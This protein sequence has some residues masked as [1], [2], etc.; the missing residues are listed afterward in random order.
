MLS[1]NQLTQ[2]VH[3]Y[4]GLYNSTDCI[5]QICKWTVRESTVGGR[6]IIATEDILCGEVLFVDRPLI[7]GPRCGNVI[8]GCTVCSKFEDD[9][10]FKCSLC[11]LLLCSTECQDFHTDDCNII[12]GWKKKV[13]IEEID[14]IV[15]SHA[16]AAIRALSLNQ[17]Q[18]QFMSALA[19][20]TLPQHGGEIIKLK[21]YFEIPEEIEKDMIFA[22]QA[23]DTNAFQIATPYGKKEMS[24]R[25]LYPVAGLMNHSC[26][27][28]A[29]YSY[30]DERQMI[31]KTSRFIAAGTEIFTCYSGILWGTTTRRS[32]LFKTKHFW[33]KCERC[34][35]PT[36]N[37]TM[38]AALCCL[39]NECTTGYLLPIEPLK[40][41]S[42]W[43]C[44]ACGLRVPSK[45]IYKIQVALGTLISTLD[46][47]NLEQMENFLM[48]RVTK[49]VPKVNHIVVDLQCR[50]IWE[51]GDVQG[52]RWHELTE[53]RLSLKLV[54]CR[55]ILAT[56]A[57]LGLED[58][59]LCGLLFYHLHATLAERARRHPDLYDGLKS[60]I[61]STIERAYRIL[62]GDI[63]APV[64]LELRYRYLGPDC[65]KPQQERFSI[66]SI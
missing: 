28:N 22:C 8:R 7:F 30:N 59:H 11:A 25:G 19:A 10:F 31:V 65:E 24:L 27:P 35:D 6:G 20:H 54:L 39:A 23:L 36:E 32:Y 33:C 17:E 42:S 14:E 29:T 3:K 21:Q 2:M 62:R 26:L 60:E 34:A 61:E 1:S 55:D 57:A 63:S 49:F 16:L 46:F 45:I 38:L 4:L 44:T 40:S 37:G 5:Q 18:K 66:L 53:S 52:Y 47:Q 12:A 50:L 13:D 56:L 41:S 58:S 51:F 48:K 64:D 9:G 43:Q 15:M